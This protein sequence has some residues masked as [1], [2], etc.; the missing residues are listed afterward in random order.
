MAGKPKQEEKEIFDKARRR[1]PGIKRGLDTELDNFIRKHKD[2]RESLPLLY[3]AVEAQSKKW[4]LEYTPKKFIPHFKTWINQRRWEQVE[5]VVLSEE[6]KQAKKN[7]EAKALEA[8]R[9]EI[10]TE[11]GPFFK[12]KT[13][14]ELRKMR[15]DRY[16]IVRWWLI[17]EI[18][19][20][21]TK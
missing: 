11:D 3:P 18:L 16:W 20:E 5:G 2:W 4:K 15:A 19:R 21:R 1:Y 10:R 12:S 7:K 9:E 14:E 13:V 8:K 17:D 6:E